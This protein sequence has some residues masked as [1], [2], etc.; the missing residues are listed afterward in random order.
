[1]Y[2]WESYCFQRNESA[3]RA[4][5]THEGQRY[6]DE[7]GEWVDEDCGRKFCGQWF[8]EDCEDEGIENYLADVL[9]KEEV[10]EYLKERPSEDFAVNVDEMSFFFKD[11]EIKEILIGQIEKKWEAFPPTG[12][13][14]V[15]LVKSGDYDYFLEW[16]EE[17]NK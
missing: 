4:A 10:I 5:L 9:T 1:M 17:R 7:C 15:E 12:K 14:L 16:Y 6:C 11:S 2:E 8:C 13:E 3:K